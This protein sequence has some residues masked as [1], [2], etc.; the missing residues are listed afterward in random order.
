MAEKLNNIIFKARGLGITTEKRS[1]FPQRLKEKPAITS[2]ILK[3]DA[4]CYSC[5]DELSAGARAVMDSRNHVYCIRCRQNIEQDKQEPVTAA[6]PKSYPGTETGRFNG[7]HQ[8]N[9]PKSWLK[10]RTR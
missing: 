4:R 6:M 2:D 5:N 3:H 7:N 8:A 10:K 9:I 1:L